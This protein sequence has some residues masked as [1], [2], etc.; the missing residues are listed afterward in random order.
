MNKSIFQLSLWFM[1]A[2]TL[3]HHLLKLGNI[4]HKN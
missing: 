1:A 4:P 3:L 2:I